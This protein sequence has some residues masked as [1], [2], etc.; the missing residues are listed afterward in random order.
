MRT[1]LLMR[2]LREL[3]SL[4]EIDGYPSDRIQK[5]KDFIEQLQQSKE[6]TFTLT[7][8]GKFSLDPRLLP[9][10]EELIQTGTSS[11]IDRLQQSIPKD[12]QQMLNIP[13]LTP[14]QIGIL[15]RKLHIDT[16]AKLQQA[17]KQQKLR[18]IP[19]FGAKVELRIR[20]SLKQL[21]NQPDRYPLAFLLS[22]A[23]EIL[24]D[25]RN[26]PEIQRS[27][28]AG[29]LR[30]YDEQMDKLVFVIA[31][32]DVTLT[33]QRL[34]DLP[35]AE[36]MIKEDEDCVAVEFSYLW[37]VPVEFHLVTIQ[38]FALRL[39]YVTG[40]ESHIKKLMSRAMELKVDWSVQ[41]IS[42]EE[43]LY[44]NLSLPYMP[45]DI[46][47]GKDEIERVIQKMP[48]LI[49]TKDF[50]GD[51]HMHSNWSDGGNSIEEMARAAFMRGYR[52]IAITDHSRSLKIA[53]GLSV[54]RL[55]QQREEIRRVEDVLKKEYGEIRIFWGVEMEILA[56][57]SLDYPDE[58]LR[59]LDI[60]IASI[61]TSFQQDEYTISK[62][63][64]DAMRNPYIDIIAHP[65]G[66]MIGRRE[67][68]RIN[69]DILFKAA[70]AY[71]KILEL[72]SNPERLDLKDE[73]VQE[74]IEKYG[75]PIAINTDAHSVEELKNIEIG[76]HYAKRGWVSPEHVINTWT[77]DQLEEYLKRK[78]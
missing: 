54:D 70:Q 53:G 15:Y 32:E 30:R 1:S 31:T 14:T 58:I 63:M 26:F 8:V 60:V 48:R 25:L 37:K 40:T 46:R 28:I 69:I 74:A 64:V 44:E 38:D 55:L 47:Q 2:Q 49:D 7:D 57:G 67:P 77:T 5:L 9:I 62:R 78:H 29:G 45:P 22:I 43:K 33:K 66:R 42:S 4:Y 51:L 23:E 18:G 65:T 13:K 20:N 10:I 50:L 35:R 24:K 73:Y 61:H 17:V 39:F 59:E 21:Q 76:V 16:M 6:H 12:V 68:Y 52:Y 27:E 71:G 19:G 3:L 75:I 36:Q 41:D 56:D 11:E 34:L 72:N